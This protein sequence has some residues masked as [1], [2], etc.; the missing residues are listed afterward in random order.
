[1]RREEKRREGNRCEDKKKTR[2]ATTKGFRYNF[3]LIPYRMYCIFM[4][5]FTGG[6]TQSVQELY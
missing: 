6:F 5:M 2:V 3:A 4:K 1:M